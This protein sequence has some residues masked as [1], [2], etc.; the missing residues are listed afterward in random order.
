MTLHDL[1][2][3]WAWLVVVSNT[4]VGV[5]FLAGHWRESARHPRMWLVA[6][7][8]Q[9]TIAVQVILGVAL[10]NRDGFDATPLHQFYGFI[11][12]ASVGI[13]YSYRQQIKQWEYLLYGFGHLF[14]MGLALRAFYG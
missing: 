10:Q 8:A 13:I 5:W 7:A 11:A 1:H 14:L 12:F 3:T 6:H 4:A 2:T 9:F